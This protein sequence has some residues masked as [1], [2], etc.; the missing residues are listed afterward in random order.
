VKEKA[1]IRSSLMSTLLVEANVGF[2]TLAK[3]FRKVD[4]PAAR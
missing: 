3:R 2:G 1:R 4:T